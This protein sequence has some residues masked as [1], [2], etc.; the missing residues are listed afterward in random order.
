MP[1]VLAHIIDNISRLHLKEIY[2]HQENMASDKKKL[3]SWPEYV[4]CDL[5]VLRRDDK[6]ETYLFCS[7]CE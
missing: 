4:L 5:M 3:N 7:A 1:L 2:S 6:N